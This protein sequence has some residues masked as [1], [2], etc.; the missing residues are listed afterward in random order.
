MKLVDRESRSALVQSDDLGPQ[1]GELVHRMFADARRTSGHHRTAA[2][3]APQVVD[4]SQHSPLNSSEFRRLPASLALLLFPGSLRRL[5][6]ALV[7][8]GHGL[9]DLGGGEV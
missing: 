9:G 5:N 1:F 7:H 8:L 6:P 2:V 4:S 3:V